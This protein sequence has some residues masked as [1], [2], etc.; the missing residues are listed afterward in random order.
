VRVVAAA[1]EDAQRPRRSPRRRCEREVDRHVMVV[2][3]MDD[4]DRRADGAGER[5]EPGGP[6]GKARQRAQGSGGAA[7]FARRV[8]DARAAA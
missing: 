6:G 1:I 4:E 3:R 8:R 2:A 7:A 5:V